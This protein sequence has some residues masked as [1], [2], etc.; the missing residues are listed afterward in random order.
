MTQQEHGC[1]AFLALLRDAAVGTE[2]PVR[3]W[4]R[5]LGM[6]ASKPVEACRLPALGACG[7]EMPA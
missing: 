6:F 1:H 4:S 3:A 2:V 5:K 7:T